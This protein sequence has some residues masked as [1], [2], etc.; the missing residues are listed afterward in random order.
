[1]EGGPVE[2]VAV[3]PPQF[4]ALSLG[5]DPDP[6]DGEDPCALARGLRNLLLLVAAAAAILWG[7]V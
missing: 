4:P 1:M 2:P 7:I 6:W 3:G 5:L